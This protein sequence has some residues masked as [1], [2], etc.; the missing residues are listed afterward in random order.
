MQKI[1]IVWICRFM[2]RSMAN[3]LNVGKNVRELHPWITLGIEEIKK[4]DDIELYVIS[5]FSEIRR[6]KSFTE[7][8]IHYYFIK[9][10]MP[11]LKREWHHKIRFDIKSEY[12]VFNYQVRVL[13][14]RIKPDLI[15]LHG[16]E[17]VDYSSS[18]LQ[19]K[20]I[21]PVLISIQG[22]VTL[23]V[24]G[25][26]T[27]VYLNQRINCEKRILSTFKYYG[28]EAIFMEN[29]VRKYNP[30]AEMFYFH[31]P[32]AK[33]T[34]TK[35]PPQEYDIVYF[36]R[37]FKNKGI[38]DLL[39][40]VKIIKEKKPNVSVV[41]C[42][43]GSDV[44]IAQIKQMIKD[45]DIEE[46]ISFKGFMPTQMD[47]HREVAKAKISV[48]P[49]YNDTIPGTIVESMLLNLSVVAYKTGAIP[50]L[51]NKGEH[52]IVVDQGDVD[53][54]ADAIFNLL[55]NDKKRTELAERGKY[56]ALEEFDNTKSIDT[57]VSI[58]KEI[59]KKENNE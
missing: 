22:F 53:G 49:T 3:R 21:Y 17:N 35:L 57:K 47:V 55:A 23:D 41:V 39:K 31:Y 10:G 2:N 20:N 48:L 12:A 59:I 42:G 8:N 46:N 34:L 51:N 30:N 56:Y 15:N 7:K 26:T 14:N 18:I 13:V 24:Q 44:Y 54:L 58:Y 25:E 19:F 11:F 5:P 40:A 43:K 28:V 4:R 6:N 50:E 16:A 27:D 29:I 9:T 45:L 52:L 37:I 1:K 38:E 36:A 32:F 33:T